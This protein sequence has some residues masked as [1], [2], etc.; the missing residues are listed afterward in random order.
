MERMQ[1]RKEYSDLLRQKAAAISQASK[2][3]SAIMPKIPSTSLVSEEKTDNLKKLSHEKTKLPSIHSINSSRQ[4][5]ASV[6][7][8]RE[9]VFSINIDEAVFAK[10]K[11][12]SIIINEFLS[13]SETSNRA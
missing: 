6:V 1:K 12:T 7:T 13:Y 10:Y 5:T 8:T 4:S 2:S 11:E 3:S 9:R